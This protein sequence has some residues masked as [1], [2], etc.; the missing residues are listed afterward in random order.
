MES[1]FPKTREQLSDDV[2]RRLQKIVDRIAPCGVEWTCEVY[3][4]FATGFATSTSDLDIFMF[5]KD[6]Q[7]VDSRTALQIISN[8][9]NQEEGFLHLSRS[10][11]TNNPILKFTDA[12]TDTDIELSVNNTLAFTPSQR[13]GSGTGYSRGAQ[14]MYR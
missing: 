9:I 3:G 1:N 7:D 12:S 10:F 6:T 4:S 13:V 2:L 8:S 5:S 11:A 14:W